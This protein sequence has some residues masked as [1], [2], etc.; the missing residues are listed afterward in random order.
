M[1]MPKN[2]PDPQFTWKLKSLVK[3]QPLYNLVSIFCNIMNIANPDTVAQAPIFNS[4]DMSWKLQSP[5]PD[6][7][8]EY[9]NSNV[10]NSDTV[11]V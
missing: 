1:A 9:I 7:L 3:V 5:Y 2:Q 8:G 4:L 10:T 6:I 11:P